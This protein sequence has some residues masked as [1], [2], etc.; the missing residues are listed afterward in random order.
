MASHNRSACWGWMLGGS[1]WL[2][3]LV[4]P[5][6]LWGCPALD[7]SSVTRSRPAGFGFHMSGSGRRWM[8]PGDLHWPLTGV[9]VWPQILGA[10]PVYERSGGHS[11]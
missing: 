3:L 1:C 10:F 2:L 7:A 11:L 8:Q 4:G 9:G 5:L 6:S